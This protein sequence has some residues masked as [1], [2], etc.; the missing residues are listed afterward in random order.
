[1]IMS[2]KWGESLNVNY[3]GLGQVS[4]TTSWKVSDAYGQ[5]VTSYTYGDGYNETPLWRYTRTRNYVVFT[6]KSA[7][8]AE[9]TLANS[10]VK[11]A[12]LLQPHVVIGLNA[13]PAKTT[14]RVLPDNTNHD[15]VLN[16][17]KLKEPLL[18][19]DIDRQIWLAWPHPGRV[20]C[21]VGP[22]PN[23]NILFDA[24]I[25]DMTIAINAIS[26]DTELTD[27]GRVP[28]EWTLT[29]DTG[30]QFYYLMAS[31]SPLRGKSWIYLGITTSW[32]TFEV[33]AGSDVSLILAY[34][35][36]DDSAGVE[37]ILQPV[38]NG[39]S[40][41]RELGK[42]IAKTSNKVLLNS[43]ETRHFWIMWTAA[44]SAYTI[45]VGQGDIPRDDTLIFQI[46]NIPKPIQAITY[47]P[48]AY[49]SAF[50]LWQESSANW[51]RFHL[52]HD[53]SSKLMMTVDHHEDLV[54][55]VQACKTVVIYLHETLGYSD[56]Y[57]YKIEIG[58][59]DNTQSYIKSRY[60]Y[61]STVHRDT[62]DILSCGKMDTFWI[63]WYTGQIRVGRGAR[64][65]HH[66]FLDFQQLQ[67]E[68][69]R[70]I[71]F[72]SY[73][74]ND[75][76]WEI[77]M[78]TATELQAQEPEVVPEKHHTAAIVVGVLVLLVL[79]AAIVSAVFVCKR[80]DNPCMKFFS[81]KGDAN[82]KRGVAGSFAES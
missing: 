58:T 61:M 22:I 13:D 36:F 12:L 56:Y 72:K 10:P 18:G 40:T 47:Y 82:E 20:A 68:V 30:D 64:I 9:I 75:S 38:E 49:T 67:P 31:D 51:G 14:L 39:I 66:F 44:E 62:P 1:V 50:F 17:L 77:P 42:A 46:A 35:M 33:K 76:L 54:F 23:S 24:S 81:S 79:V 52:N 6:V 57:T 8:S 43:L 11:S 29:E 19:H 2:T 71:S 4:G 45:Q 60:D 34:E 15:L 78:L 70:G 37:V 55:S 3:V 27:M 65:G 41:I 21:G 5:A 69:V 28:G 25:D 16:D 74:H 53:A 48:G 80:E 59:E 73:S 32:T 63:T 26:F 7:V